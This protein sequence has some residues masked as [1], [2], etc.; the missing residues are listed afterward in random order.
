M[1]PPAE[2]LKR[3]ARGCELFAEHMANY[4]GSF[5]A[6]ISKMSST[7]A[8]SLAVK[9][10][11]FAVVSLIRDRDIRGYRQWT[12]RCGLASLAAARNRDPVR[13]QE[14]WGPIFVR[15]LG[16]VVAGGHAELANEF[17]KAVLRRP[18]DTDTTMG[19]PIQQ[20]L[21]PLWANVSEGDWVTARESAMKLIS[22]ATDH[23]KPYS[24]VPMAIVAALDNSRDNAVAAVKLALREHR[25]LCEP[26]QRFAHSPSDHL[27]CWDAV[28]LVRTLAVRGVNVD[29]DDPLLPPGSLL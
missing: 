3:T 8:N 6:D 11:S 23:G 10:P 28:A 22:Y 25:L 5:P 26:G 2:A 4:S 17:A 27:I 14:Y 15:Q 20:L 7:A 9:A 19:L 16:V 18:C 13:E 29:I 21:A 24:G 1:I 12:E